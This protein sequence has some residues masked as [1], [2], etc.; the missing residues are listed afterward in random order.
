MDTHPLP[1]TDVFANEACKLYFD[2]ELSRDSLLLIA[3]TADIM[4]P[5]S[6]L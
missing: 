6:T 3:I 2:E 1:A 4:D 5:V